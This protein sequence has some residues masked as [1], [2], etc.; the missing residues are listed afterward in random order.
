MQTRVKSLFL[1]STVGACAALL[2]VNQSQAQSPTP[3][4]SPHSSSSPGSTSYQGFVMGSKI[5]GCHVKDKQGADLGTISDVV[6]NPDT[7][8]IRFAIVNAGGKSV[9]VPWSGLNVE[10]MSG[11]Q[12]PKFVLDT[13]EAKLKSAPAFDASKLSQM[14]TR[15]MEE[16]MFVYYDIVWFPD[17]LTPDEQT[18][19]DKA[20]SGGTTSSGASPHATATP[21]S[22]ATP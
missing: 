14:Y 5:A 1:L 20:K 17:V 11:G 3:M 13:T 8:H 19:K 21:M 15:M 18:A 12:A 16:P 4:S 10:T 9:A 22:S 2:C 6:V 7:G